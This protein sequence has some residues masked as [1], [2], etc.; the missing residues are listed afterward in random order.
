MRHRCIS[1]SEKSVCSLFS[2]GS[3]DKQEEK[4]KEQ[5][6]KL[7]KLNSKLNN[8]RN[9][10]LL[11]QSLPAKVHPNLDMKSKIDGIQALFQ[12]K[13]GETINKSVIKHSNTSH[14]VIHEENENIFI[15]H[16][17]EDVV[18]QMIINK[19]TRKYKVNKK[20]KKEF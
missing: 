6:E 9:S 19:P 8:L 17:E 12:K 15:N 2:T 4:A 20:S 10:Q 18:D 7:E 3:S 5:R 11:R 13:N 14:F 1:V 16:N